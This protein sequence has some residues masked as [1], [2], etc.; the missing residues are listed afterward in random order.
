MQRAPIQKYLAGATIRTNQ[1]HSESSIYLYP[2]FT[3]KGT[4]EEKTN[5]KRT[6]ALTCILK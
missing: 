5:P 1:L 4:K 6:P 3:F 2:E